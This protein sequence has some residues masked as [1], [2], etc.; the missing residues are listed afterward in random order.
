MTAKYLSL[1]YVFTCHAVPGEGEMARVNN[2]IL[3]P[4][5]YSRYDLLLF[6]I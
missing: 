6:Y 2:L 3:T 5:G 4:I 1:I